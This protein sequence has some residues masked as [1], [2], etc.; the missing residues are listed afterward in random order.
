MKY[1]QEK[2]KEILTFQIILIKF[3]TST[4]NKIRNKLLKHICMPF[5][6]DHIVLKLKTFK[7]VL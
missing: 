7:T 3:K 5:F 6:K 2:N 1:I 4:K